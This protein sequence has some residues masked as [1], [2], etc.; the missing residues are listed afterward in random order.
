MLGKKHESGSG[1]LALEI[2]RPEK[3]PTATND[4]ASERHDSPDLPASPVAEAA[5]LVARLLSERDEPVRVDGDGPASA[6]SPE[7]AGVVRA[8]FTTE[9]APVAD[10]PVAPKDTEVPN[11]AGARAQ[12]P[13]SKRSFWLVIVL[14]SVLIFGAGLAVG[15]GIVARG[16]KGGSIFSAQKADASAV[17]ASGLSQP[18]EGGNQ[19]N[20]AKGPG[21]PP[22]DE[23]V[24]LPPVPAASTQAATKAVSENGRDKDFQR[25]AADARIAPSE[26]IHTL[27][28]TPRAAADTSALDKSLASIEAADAA[29]RAF[30]ATLHEKTA[31]IVDPPTS[32]GTTGTSTQSVH[33]DGTATASAQLDNMLPASEMPLVAETS[34]S[35]GAIPSAPGDQNLDAGTSDKPIDPTAASA[36][37]IEPCQLVY[38]VQ[39]VYPEKA[40]QLRVEGDVQLRVVVAVDGSVR[41]VGLVSG[42]PML[43]MA[44]IDAAREFRYKPATL[45]GKPIETV[46]SVD[47]AFKLKN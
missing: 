46:Q 11:P 20:A 21:A 10:L 33:A 23:A 29:T 26:Q 39:P 8:L 3:R 41:Y 13:Y 17:P 35:S 22:V 19:A 7:P 5:A 36:G 24:N 40:K 42:P 6:P 47:M 4:A 32:G 34:A 30:N 45:N 28:V 38:S 14:V 44:A 16:W 2:S 12:A 15:Y 1:L 18:V 31:P 25:P 27:S 9:S 43:V 37:Q